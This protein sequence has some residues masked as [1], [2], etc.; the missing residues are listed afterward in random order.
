M[1]GSIALLQAV[2]RHV[3]THGMEWEMCLG[4]HLGA[5]SYAIIWYTTIFK[6]FDPV[7]M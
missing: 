7:A 2:T 4:C 1:V 3:N 5:S 6:A